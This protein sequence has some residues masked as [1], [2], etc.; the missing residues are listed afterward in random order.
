[1]DSIRHLIHQTIDANEINEVIDSYLKEDPSECLIEVTKWLD[2]LKNSV[3]LY[4]Y[5]YLC[6]CIG[7]VL[8]L[9]NNRYNTLHNASKW[10]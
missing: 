7:S 3:T 4:G 10:Q 5:D 6:V 9:L 1:M 2:T 8:E